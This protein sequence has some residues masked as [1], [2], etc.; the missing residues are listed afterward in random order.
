MQMKNPPHP[1]RIVREEI[2]EA[3]GLTVGEAAEALGVSRPHLS[4]LLNGKAGISPEMAIRLSK[5]LGNGNP[6]FWLRLQK[7][8]ELAQA[9]W[10]NVAVTQAFLTLS[11]VVGHVDLLIDAGLVREVADGEIVR[12]EATGEAGEVT[13]PP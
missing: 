10:G 12:F 9:L 8:Y 7:Q 13:I 11:E 1:G 6:D 3:F 5:A 4:Q 2:I